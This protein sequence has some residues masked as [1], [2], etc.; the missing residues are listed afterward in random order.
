MRNVSYENLSNICKEIIKNKEPDDAIKLISNIKTEDNC[1]IGKDAAKKIY[2][3]Y[4]KE[5]VKYT[6]NKYSEN[7][8]E[9][10]KKVNKNIKKACGKKSLSDSNKFNVI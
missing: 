9:Y 10:K 7:I 6:S 3:L 8:T 4:S 2:K 1:I 5:S